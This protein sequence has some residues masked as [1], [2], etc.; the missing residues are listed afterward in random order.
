GGRRGKGPPPRPACPRVAPRASLARQDEPA[1]PVRQG[2]WRLTRPILAINGGPPVRPA[3]RPWPRWP[4]YTDEARREVDA[5]LA[6]GRWA[7]SGPRTGEPGRARPL[8]GQVAA[9]HR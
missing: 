1:A 7:V 8:A 3:G 2:R 4:R 9:V 6:S 5:A